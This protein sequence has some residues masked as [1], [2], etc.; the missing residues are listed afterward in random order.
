M[1]RTSTEPLYML[2]KELSKEVSSAIDW[3]SEVGIRHEFMQQAILQAQNR[4]ISLAVWLPCEIS[5]R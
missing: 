4:V 5:A 3:E 1:F 2:E